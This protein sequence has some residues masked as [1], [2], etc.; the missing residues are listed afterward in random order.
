MTTTGVLRPPV[1]RGSAGVR[2]SRIEA[3]GLLGLPGVP[4]DP[5]LGAASRICSSLDPGR[6][7]GTDFEPIFSFQCLNSPSSESRCPPPSSHLPVLVLVDGFSDVFSPLSG[8]QG[9]PRRRGLIRPEVPAR[10]Q[11]RVSLWADSP[12]GPGLW[13]MVRGA[14]QRVGEERGPEGAL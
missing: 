9:R 3:R 2:A 4:R 8:L 5:R 12:P 7:P 11:P 10:A 1:G 6:G 14:T 13:W